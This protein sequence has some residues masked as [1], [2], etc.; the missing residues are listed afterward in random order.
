LTEYSGEF[1]SLWRTSTWLV[2]FT[3][4]LR[5]SL[6]NSDCAALSSAIQ[7]SFSQLPWGEY[8]HTL[9]PNWTWIWEDN[10]DYVMMQSIS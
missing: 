10:S 6:F 3:R 1:G 7:I 4:L 2:V 9:K 5:I 8:T